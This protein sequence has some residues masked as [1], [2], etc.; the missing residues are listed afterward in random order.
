MKDTLGKKIENGMSINN[1]FKTRETIIFNT[2][3][4]DTILNEY[5]GLKGVIVRPLTETEVDIDDVGM[6]Y[7]VCLE[8]NL[9]IDAFE[10]ELIK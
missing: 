2:H 1:N 10:D 4:G 8:N 3:G 5:S 6:M 7:K 9:E